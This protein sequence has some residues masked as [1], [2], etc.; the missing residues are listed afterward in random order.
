MKLSLQAQFTTLSVEALA[1]EASLQKALTRLPA[2]FKDVG[3]KLA[4]AVAAPIQALFVP[5][6]VTWAAE[7]LS[8]TNYAD[9]RT[10]SFPCVPG[11]KGDYLTYITALSKATHYARQIEVLFLDPLITY[12]AAKISN[13]EALRS[14]APDAS[15]DSITLTM[16][17]QL[18]RTMAAVTDAHHDAATQPYGKLIKRNSDW[19]QVAVHAQEIHHAFAQSDQL[20]FQ[21]KVQR[22]DELLGALIKRVTQDSTLYK[23]S[24]KSLTL[25]A[26]KAYYTATAV[27]FYGLTFRRS[28]VLDHQLGLLVDAAKKLQ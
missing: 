26:E 19:A 24:G 3:T 5:K 17:N 16:L 21:R 10:V 9:M 13:P 23:V 7:V 11:L 2:F 6:D 18:T 8:K 4:D 20:A 12:L 28:L 1:G 14:L 22:V 15:L 27:E 25:L